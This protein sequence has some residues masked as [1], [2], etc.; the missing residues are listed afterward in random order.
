MEI[1]IFI[2]GRDECES[3][4]VCVCTEIEI[5]S[6][7]FEKKQGCVYVDENFWKLFLL[8]V[9]IY[10]FNLYRD[11]KIDVSRGQKALF[12]LCFKV[13]FEHFECEKCKRR[14]SSFTRFQ[15][16]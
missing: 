13:F 15:N 1:A 11:K 7:F 14:F 6:F 5:L 8:S 10:F 12:L 2:S 3:E 4:S 16:T 9:R